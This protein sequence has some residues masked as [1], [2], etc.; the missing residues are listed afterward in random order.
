M[1]KRYSVFYIIGCVASAC[2]GILAY[3]VR[4]LALAHD[5]RI[6]DCNSLCKWMV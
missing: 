6:A 4:N 3:G 1:G 2:S 5:N